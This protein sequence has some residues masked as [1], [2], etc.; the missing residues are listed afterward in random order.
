[1]LAIAWL[2]SVVGGQTFAAC[3]W[4][5]GDPDSGGNHAGY[6]Y[7]LHTAV[8]VSGFFLWVVPALQH[9]YE[10]VA[11]KKKLPAPAPAPAQYGKGGYSGTPEA[12]IHSYDI[13]NALEGA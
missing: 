12:P 2:F 3:Y 7:W 8:D 6:S 1:M 11:A 10:F 9:A 13:E 4:D 5:L